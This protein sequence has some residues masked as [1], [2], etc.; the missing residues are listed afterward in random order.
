MTGSFTY[1][2]IKNRENK[3][4]SFSFR[5]KQD[6]NLLYLFKVKMSTSDEKIAVARRYVN[7]SNERNFEAIFSLFE[8][9]AQYDSQSL[10]SSELYTLNGLDK[11]K[12]MMLEYYNQTSPDVKWI[13]EKDFTMDLAFGKDH[14][15][16]VFDFRGQSNANEQVNDKRG[17]EWVCVNQQGKIY[18]IKSIAL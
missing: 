14:D 2:M 13:V 17:R 8:Q 3:T 10:T 11:I 5:P 1:P 15:A 9:D 12:E 4:C 7:S 18:Y 6:N 16:V